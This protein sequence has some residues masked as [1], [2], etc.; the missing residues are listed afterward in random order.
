MIL[1]FKNY[2]KLTYRMHFIVI[3]IYKILLFLNSKINVLEQQS[4][5]RR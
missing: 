5:N 4:K 1:I 2:H 3:K